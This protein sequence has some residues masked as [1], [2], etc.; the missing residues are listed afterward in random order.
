[1]PNSV[2]FGFKVVTIPFW[3]SVSSLYVTY[4]SEINVNLWTP[5]K[6]YK[7]DKKRNKLKLVYTFDN[8]N[9]VG[10]KEG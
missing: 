4:L 9:V 1:M 5:Y 2:N 3:V 7:Y 10:I 6:L 8:E